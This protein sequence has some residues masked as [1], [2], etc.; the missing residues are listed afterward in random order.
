[1]ERENERHILGLLCLSAMQ[2]VEGL[3][4]LVSHRGCA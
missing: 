3:R 4:Q 2:A 1:M